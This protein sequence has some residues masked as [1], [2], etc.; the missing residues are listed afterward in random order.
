[1]SRNL[2]LQLSKTI[3]TFLTSKVYPNP[4]KPCNSSLDKHFINSFGKTAEDLVLA[5][6]LHL[7]S[8]AAISYHTEPFAFVLTAHF[9]Y[10][11]QFLQKYTVLSTEKLTEIKVAFVYVGSQISKSNKSKY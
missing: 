1:M 4:H 7:L 2:Y 10:Y 3:D 6:P 11:L 5:H 9:N 8:L